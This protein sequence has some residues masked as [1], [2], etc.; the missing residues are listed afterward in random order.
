MEEMSVNHCRRLSACRTRPRRR[1]PGAGPGRA[2]ARAAA[3][4]PSFLPPPELAWSSSRPETSRSTSMATGFVPCLPM[5][6]V[7]IVTSLAFACSGRDESS[8]LRGAALARQP[9]R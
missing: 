6:E 9:R 4:S 2:S 1:A 7:V 5:V 8:P 3:G